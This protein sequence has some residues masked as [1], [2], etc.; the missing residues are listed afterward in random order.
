MRIFYLSKKRIF[1]FTSIVSLAIFTVLLAYGMVMENISTVSKN[2]YEPLYQG[3]S[4]KKEIAIT[5][6]VVWGE[7]FIPQMLEILRENNVKITFNVGGDWAGKFPNLTK[8]LADGK[9][10]LG[11]HGYSHPHPAQISYDK[12]VEE[13]IKTQEAIYKAAKV[14]TNLFAPPYGE[15]NQKVLWAAG[16]HGYRT[17]LWSIDTIDWQ[18]PQPE[19]IVQRVLQKAHNGGIILMHPTAPTVK[20]LPTMLKELKKRGYKLVTVTELLDK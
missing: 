2:T 4:N 17:I 16:E 14:K 5:C 19:V 20:A 8:A 1:N 13:I 15:F 9:H 6:N 12:N 11:N 7:E 3:D 18:R 10:E